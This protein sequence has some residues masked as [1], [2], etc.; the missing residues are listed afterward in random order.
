MKLKSEHI[1]KEFTE[2][3]TLDGFR[4]IIC[5][6]LLNE[7]IKQWLNDKNIIYKLV[8]RKSAYNT[9]ILREI[10]FWNYVYKVFT[11]DDHYL[12]FARYAVKNPHPAF[13]HFLA[14]PRKIIPFY[15]RPIS[16][17]YLYVIKME[18]LEPI[19]DQELLNW[20][21]Q[22]LEYESMHLLNK[23]PNQ[24]IIVDKN[25]KENLEKV[26][27]RVKEMYLKYPSLKTLVE[28]YAI[29]ISQ[30][31]FQ[32]SPDI[33]KGNFMQRSNGDIVIIDP[34]WEGESIYQ[35]YDRALKAETDYNDDND[36]DE[37]GNVIDVPWG[38]YK[39]GTLKTYGKKPKLKNNFNDDDIPF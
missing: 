4:H 18:K 9:D 38:F 2:T 26:Q 14:K 30:P 37:E 31:Q 20:I 33:H 23:T 7:E 28:G 22:N 5:N 32:S 36:Y 11:H 17:P 1:T 21:V 34:F 16:D 39:G 19:Q 24:F 13:P 27:N 8:C 35:M 10:V 6:Q 15:K 12:R 25:P 3:K 29:L